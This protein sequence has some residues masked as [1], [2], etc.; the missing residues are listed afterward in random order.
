LG[1]EVNTNYQ[2]LLSQIVRDILII[3]TLRK[4]CAM[5][6]MYVC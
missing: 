4:H 3:R 2:E 6:R 5:V 1:F